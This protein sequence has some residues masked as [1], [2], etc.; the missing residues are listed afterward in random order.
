MHRRRWARTHLNKKTIT[1]VVY[2]V[3]LP[4]RV[5]IHNNHQL[6]CSRAYQLRSVVC[7][8]DE[9]MRP[10]NIFHVILFRCRVPR[11]FTH[12]HRVVEITRLNCT[13]H[14]AHAWLIIHFR[15]LR[16]CIKRKYVRGK[17]L[18]LYKLYLCFERSFVCTADTLYRP[19][20]LYVHHIYIRNI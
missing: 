9:T 17:L 4:T 5:C 19:H 11:S 3:G 15:Y 13:T 12:P 18:T 1:R 6:L 2:V 16:R 8:L 10:C 14:G 20:R 7:F